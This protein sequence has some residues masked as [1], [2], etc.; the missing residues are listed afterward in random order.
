MT[1]Y[2]LVMYFYR[3]NRMDRLDRF[4]TIVLKRLEQQGFD[5]VASDEVF[6]ELVEKYTIQGW[7]PRQKFHLNKQSCD[8]YN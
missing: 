2:S 3:R 6:N 4:M 7:K 8:E 1:F 5:K